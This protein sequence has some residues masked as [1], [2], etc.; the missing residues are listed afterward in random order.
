[1]RAPRYKHNIPSL[2]LSV[3]TMLAADRQL[4][5]AHLRNEMQRLRQLEITNVVD[6]YGTALTPATLIA[7]FSMIGMSALDM[8]DDHLLAFDEDMGSKVEVAEPIFYLCTSVALAAS[9]YVTA[10]STTGIVFG[11]RLTIQATVQQGADHAMTVQELNG[12]FVMSLIAL[13]VA[14]VLVNIAALCVVW[15]KDITSPAF[16]AAKRNYTR[17]HPGRN[18]D[19]ILPGN[20]YCPIVAACIFVIFFTCAAV[21]VGQMISRLHTWRPDM[22]DI[23]LRQAGR[24]ATER[25]PVKADEF[26][27]AEEKA[28]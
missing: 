8:T 15:T 11:Q 10:I 18:E 12:K 21:S 2:G 20:Y 3:G 17:S 27:V 23:S 28:P 25:S 6:R 13:A 9:L 24:Q 4:L 5:D 16:A 26:F 7:G 19:D 1:M 14:L 22:A